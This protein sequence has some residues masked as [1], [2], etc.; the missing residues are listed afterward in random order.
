MLAELREVPVICICTRLALPRNKDATAV[1]KL[2]YPVVL[3]FICIGVYS[4][5]NSAFDV[6]QLVALGRLGY[7]VR[8]FAF[9][10]APMLQGFVPGPMLEEQFR[11]AL[12]LL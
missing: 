5:S 6:W 8:V 2:L 3:M 9:I 7:S 12:I 11:R 1:M 10:G 4:F